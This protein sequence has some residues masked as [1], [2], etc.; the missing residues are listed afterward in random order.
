[1]SIRNLSN[2]KLSL[3]FGEMVGRTHV[4]FMNYDGSQDAD[5]IP[6]SSELSYL[7]PYLIR[8]NTRV[9]NEPEIIRISTPINTEEGWLVEEVWLHHDGEIILNRMV[10]KSLPRAICIIMLES[11]QRDLQEA[12]L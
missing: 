10:D 6:Y 4:F 2:E 12:N 5:P 3:L 11:K 9:G 1:M 8:F 7:M